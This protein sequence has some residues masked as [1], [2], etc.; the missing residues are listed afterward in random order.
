MEV[1]APEALQCW[2]HENTYTRNTAHSHTHVHGPAAHAGR[3]T[4]ARQPALVDARC[5]V[6]SALSC[7]GLLHTHSLFGYQ[8]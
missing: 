6:V 7:L 1:R 2:A 8:T 3:Y 5:H 4:G